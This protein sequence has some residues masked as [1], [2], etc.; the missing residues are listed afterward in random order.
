MHTTSIESG[1]LFA[2]PWPEP[3]TRSRLTILAQRCLFPTCSKERETELA[4]EVLAHHF[5]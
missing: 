3:G 4:L 2:Y 5:D 1:P